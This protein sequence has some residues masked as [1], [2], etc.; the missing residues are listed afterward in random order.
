MKID[1]RTSFNDMR[2]DDSPVSIKFKSSYI[3]IAYKIN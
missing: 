2:Q 3:L 1:S